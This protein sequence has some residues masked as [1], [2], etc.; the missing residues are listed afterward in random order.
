VLDLVSD[1]ET[2][3]RN[4]PLTEGGGILVTTI[5]VADEAWFRERDIRAINIVMNQTP[6]S[7]PAGLD[8]VA[9]M[10]AE[11][12]LVVKIASERPLS[13]ANAV[14]DGIKSGAIAGKV[15]LRP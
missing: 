8:E 6:Q 13:E 9:R 12:T 10:V 15:I 1:G 7:S 14:L 3:K 11:G 2:L 4:A 5:H